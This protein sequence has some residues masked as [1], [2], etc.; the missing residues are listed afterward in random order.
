VKIGKKWRSGAQAS[1]I[2]YQRVAILFYTVKVLVGRGDGS[3]A[4]QGDRTTGLV[5]GGEVED[6][7]AG[8][9]SDVSLS[10]GL[11]RGRRG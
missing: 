11:H 5:V 6:L 9:D 8:V 4:C 3:E 2:W 7:L 1:Y 10:V